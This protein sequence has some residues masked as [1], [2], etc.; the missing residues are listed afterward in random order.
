MRGDTVKHWVRPHPL[1]LSVISIHN[2]TTWKGG[3]CVYTVLLLSIVILAN[4]QTILYPL[5]VKYEINPSFL[6][7]DGYRYILAE[8][9]PHATV[10]MD[11]EEMAGRAIPPELYRPYM[12]TEVLLALHDRG[13]CGVDMG[14]DRGKGRC[15]S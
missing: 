14:H 12:P 13:K 15:G 5:N 6:C 4:A 1:D 8:K 7:Q 9:D 3:V 10:E 2:I 11:P